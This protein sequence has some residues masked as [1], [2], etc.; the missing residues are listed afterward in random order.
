MSRM[1]STCHLHCLTFLP[2]VSAVS[3]HL[4]HAQYSTCEL[5]HLTLELISPPCAFPC[6]QWCP[7]F[8][9]RQPQ[10]VPSPTPLPTQALLCPLHS[11]M[12]AHPTPSP[13]SLIVSTPSLPPPPSFL[14]L[15]PVLGAEPGAL[16]TEG[17][18]SV[19]G[20]TPALV[21]I[22]CSVWLLCFETKSCSVAH[23]GLEVT[24]FLPLP[25]ECEVTGVPTT[26]SPVS[27]QHI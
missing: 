7:D 9:P 27:T 1:L 3:T 14:S 25:P 26:S 13:S 24:P 12:S 17:K 16:H 22:V 10:P 2:C 20:T 15:S 11:P 6:L 18:C 23:N 21:F 4:L 19:P 5:I 8:W